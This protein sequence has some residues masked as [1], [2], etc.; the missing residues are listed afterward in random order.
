MNSWDNGA[1]G[2]YW[3]NYNGT[4]NNGDE[5]GDTPYIIAESNQDN[6]P[7]INIIP[8]FPSLIPLLF[9]FTVLAVTLAILKRKIHHS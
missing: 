2:N 6:Y 3:N 8:E 9:A 1:E 4:D 5:I 7:L